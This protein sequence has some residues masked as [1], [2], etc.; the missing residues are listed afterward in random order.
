LTILSPH[1]TDAGS[2]TELS[3]SATTD[4][5]NTA[6]IAGIVPSSGT[7]TSQYSG[8]A[9]NLPRLLEDWRSANLNLNT[10]IVC[11]YNSTWATGQFLLPGNY[12]YAPAVRNFTF[13]PIFTNS[14]GMP[15]GTPNICRLIRS[16]WC[17]PQPN[18]T[19]YPDITM[20]FVPH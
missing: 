19:S 4:T 9:N 1:W 10:S 20:D 15:P 8:G 2:T 5:L 18:N 16:S 7:G 12:Y 6:F 17:N 13:N 11:L 14:A 3:E